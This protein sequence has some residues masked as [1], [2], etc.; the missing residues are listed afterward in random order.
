M[1]L[2]A[3]LAII[4]LL[5][6]LLTGIYSIPPNEKGVVRRFGKRVPQL[7]HSGMH[8]DLPWPFTNVDRVKFNELRTLTFGEM[9]VDANFLE[10]TA[11]TPPVTFLTGDRN[12][13]LLRISIQYRIS[14]QEI[15]H[16][17]FRCL[18]PATQL[19]VI[20]E[21]AVA[22]FVSRCGVD[23]VHTHGLA[24]LNHLLLDEIRTRVRQT[25]L[26]CEIELVSLDRLEPPARVKP[27][28]LDVSNARADKARMIHDAT[29]Y[30][31]RHLA[32]CQADA[33]KLI[34]DANQLHHSLVTS[35]ESS[36]DRF[37]R[38]VAQIQQDAN[39]SGRSY[40]AS[41]QIVVNRQTIDALQEV[42]AKLTL[43]FV[44]DHSQPLDVFYNK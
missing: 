27:D 39:S 40:A 43:K 26:G 31:E 37:G 22:D 34:D 25:Q 15:E 1:R 35:A 36:A 10:S 29:S 4:I 18:D 17:S 28:F 6:Y 32:E 16:W 30:A 2:R 19:Q 24:Q 9:E 38:L 5:A 21:T 8:L 44:S 13:L 41:R 23:F 12:L 3:T 7:S 11:A 20:V 33:R 42:M 14:D